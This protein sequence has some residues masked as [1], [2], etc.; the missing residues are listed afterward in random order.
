L[1]SKLIENKNEQIIGEMDI[2]PYDDPQCDNKSI[3]FGLSVMG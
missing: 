3:F 2:V 1:K